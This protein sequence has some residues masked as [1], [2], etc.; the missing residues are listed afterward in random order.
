M[1]VMEEIIKKRTEEICDRITK[2]EWYRDIQN[3]LIEVR[4]PICEQNNPV[5]KLLDTY[6][7]LCLELHTRTNEIIYAEGYKDG[8]LDIQKRHL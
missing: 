3:R 7:L 2:E 4:R 6:D 5:M 1:S 8:L